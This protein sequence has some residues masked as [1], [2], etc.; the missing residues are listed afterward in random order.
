MHVYFCLLYLACV[1]FRNKSCR[2]EVP[3][4]Q[5]GTFHFYVAAL[6]TAIA[7]TIRVHVLIA[8]L[9]F[10]QLVHHKKGYIGE[11]W[12]LFSRIASPR[13]SARSS[14]SRLWCN[15][16]SLSGLGATLERLASCCTWLFY[17]QPRARGA[18]KKWGY[19]QAGC[20]P[21]SFYCMCV[22]AFSNGRETTTA[23][24]VWCVWGTH[25][26][27]WLWLSRLIQPPKASSGCGSCFV[28][29]PG[30]FEADNPFGR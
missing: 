1:R 17:S 2:Q 5:Y 30:F 15:A 7:Q 11:I 9:F 26:K 25:E 10:R 6:H 4:E 3:V 12:L 21:F 16:V 29:M 20:T 24:G 27:Y 28:P 22:H 14:A 19:A 18:R 23:P 8:L 13:F